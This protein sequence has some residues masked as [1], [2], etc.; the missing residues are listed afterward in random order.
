MKCTHTER[1]DRG[2]VE[3]R[4]T[5][6]RERKRLRARQAKM[7]T[8][9]SEGHELSGENVLLIVRKEGHVERRCRVCRSKSLK[10]GGMPSLLAVG[11]EMTKT[12]R[13]LELD[14]ARER[15]AVWWEREAIK[16]EM[17]RIQRGAG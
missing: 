11:I 15:A 1:D 16:A 2:C 10:A 5:K 17:R 6:D 7:R 4:R 8:H 9:C 3:C 14:D 13:I 12:R